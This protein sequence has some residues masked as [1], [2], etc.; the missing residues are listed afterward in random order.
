[1][2]TKCLVIPR[3]T[4]ATGPT[5]ITKP[6]STAKIGGEGRRRAALGGMGLFGLQEL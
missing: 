6:G 5:R 1:M 4:P 2:T 3:Q